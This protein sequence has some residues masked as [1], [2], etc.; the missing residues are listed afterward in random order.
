MCGDPAAWPTPTVVRASCGTYGCAFAPRTGCVGW[1]RDTLAE[2][3][4]P[5]LTTLAAFLPRRF[6]RL[7]RPFDDETAEADPVG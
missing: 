5:V 3:S 7:V 1:V 2:V 6:S 4:W